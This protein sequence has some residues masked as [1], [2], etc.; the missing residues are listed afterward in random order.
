MDPLRNRNSFIWR[1]FYYF[2]RRKATYRKA[3]IIWSHFCKT[4]RNIHTQM[5]IRIFENDGKWKDAYLVGKQVS[6]VNNVDGEG[7]RTVG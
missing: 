3:Y 5:Y 6:E 7:E 4:N 1:Y 2:R